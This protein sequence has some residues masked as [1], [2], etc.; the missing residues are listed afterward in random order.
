MWLA[1]LVLAVPIALWYRTTTDGHHPSAGALE[2]LSSKARLRFLP[3]VLLFLALICGAIAMSQPQVP[4]VHQSGTSAQ[5][6]DIMI[7]LDYSGSMAEPIEGKVV[8][9]TSDDAVLQHFLDQRRK[10]LQH[11]EAGNRRIDAAQNGILQFVDSR[12][13][14]VAS[15]GGASTDQVGLICF[16]DKPRLVWPLSPDL[17]QVIMHGAFPPKGKGAQGLGEGT[18][19]GSVNPGPIDL[20]AAHFSEYGLS[21]TS[22]LVLLSDGENP[23]ED[24]VQARLRSVLKN[25]K[26]HLYLIGIGPK[27]AD[28][29]IAK[30]TTASG[31]KVF[32]VESSEQ[33]TSCFISIDQLESS[34]LPLNVT[35]AFR[36]MFHIPLLLSALLAVLALCVEAVMRGR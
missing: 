26:I 24:S 31:G 17:Q 13:K 19:F 8:P 33:W 34:Q 10:W 11:E 2:P 25:A 30:V 12:L 21:K 3:R 35:Q 29:D 36:E 14:R 23:L 18:N 1:L 7:A 9:F 27:S 20:A 16:D 5:G 4:D 32:R 28:S 6:R 22:V 15:S